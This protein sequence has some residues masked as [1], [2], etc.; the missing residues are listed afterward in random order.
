MGFSRPKIFFQFDTCHCSVVIPLLFHPSSIPST[1][2]YS[3]TNIPA[4]I[5]ITEASN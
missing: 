3:I 4:H 2:V 1:V 5:A